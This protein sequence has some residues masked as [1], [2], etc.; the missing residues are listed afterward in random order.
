MHTPN[1]D[2]CMDTADANIELDI[3]ASDATKDPPSWLNVTTQLP[4]PFRCGWVVCN[5]PGF[6]QCWFRDGTGW[7][8]LVR[9]IP[10]AYNTQSGLNFAQKIG[11]GTASL[12]LLFSSRPIPQAPWGEVTVIP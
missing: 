5:A 2:P 9:G 6:K 10:L 11:G 4:A 1:C 8:P 7:H 3:S 12:A